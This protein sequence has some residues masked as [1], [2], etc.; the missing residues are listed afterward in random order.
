MRKGVKR[1]LKRKQKLGKRVKSR[2]SPFMKRGGA[3]QRDVCDVL[4]KTLKQFNTETLPNM[5]EGDLH[6]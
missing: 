5:D 3:H 4:Y 6:P 1:T 2:R